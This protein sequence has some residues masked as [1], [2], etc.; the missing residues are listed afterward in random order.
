LTS[1]VA[2]EGN[3]SER[4][5]NK[6][7][8][9]DGAGRDVEPIRTKGCEGKPSKVGALLHRKILLVVCGWTAI[10]KKLTFPE[11]LRYV[12]GVPAVNL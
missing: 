11:R 2:D 12:G 5:A 6:P 3:S 1:L 8:R 9:T 10:S 7:W 4:H